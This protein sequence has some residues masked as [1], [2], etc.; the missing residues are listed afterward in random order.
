MSSFELEFL[1]YTLPFISLRKQK[2]T[3]ALSKHENLTPSAAH[4]VIS[5][6]FIWN[7]LPPTSFYFLVSYSLQRQWGGVTKRKK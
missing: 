4:V 6:K 2:Q 3:L 7:F 1:R 5:H